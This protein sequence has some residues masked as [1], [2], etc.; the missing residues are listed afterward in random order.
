M[1]NLNHALIL[2]V[3]A[4]HASLTADLAA[5]NVRIRELELASQG[6]AMASLA[7]ALDAIVSEAQRQLADLVTLEHELRMAGAD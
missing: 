7:V 3:D 4:A 5:L 1:L 6:V 2:R